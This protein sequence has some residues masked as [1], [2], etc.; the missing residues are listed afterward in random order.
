M[1]E[2]N[3]PTPAD[4]KLPKAIRV[5]DAHL[6]LHKRIAENQEAEARGEKLLEDE[7]IDD[8]VAKLA[9]EDEAW[10]Q[11]LQAERQNGPKPKSRGF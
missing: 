3:T 8:W 9:H 2:S 6:D 10:W 4:S 7:E 11:A 5:G 1:S